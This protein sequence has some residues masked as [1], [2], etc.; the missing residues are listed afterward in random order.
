MPGKKVAETGWWYLGKVK[1][2]NAWLGL[3]DYGFA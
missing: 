1:P 3:L 2:M